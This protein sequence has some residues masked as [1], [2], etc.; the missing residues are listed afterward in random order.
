M[1]AASMA[2]SKQCDGVMGATMGTGASPWRLYMA[3]SR[4]DC[5]VLVGR[6]VE[7][8]PRWMLMTRSGSSRLTAMPTDSDLRS[9]PGP[10]VVVTPREPPK[11]AP[12]AA[13]T[14]AIS[15]SACTVRTPNSLCLESSWRMSEAGVMGYEPRK[16]GRWAWCAAAMRPQASAVLPV[17]L[18]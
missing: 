8:P 18:V 17:M 9:A 14:P 16:S 15:S 7:G 11:A 13:P 2:T 10:L 6:P 3:W 1:R 5:S 4:S 12:M